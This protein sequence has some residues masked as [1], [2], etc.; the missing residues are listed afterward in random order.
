MAFEQRWFLH[1]SWVLDLW[2]RL[3]CSVGVQE[4]APRRRKATTTPQNPANV[5]ATSASV[6][7]TVS[8]NAS[9]YVTPPNL[10]NRT[11]KR[12]GLLAFIAL[13][14][15]IGAQPQRNVGKLHRLPY[16]PH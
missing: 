7:R 10:F 1:S 11:H 3:V 16:H 8:F 6:L 5:I 12:S 14:D 9:G 4:C 15:G 2:P 13:L